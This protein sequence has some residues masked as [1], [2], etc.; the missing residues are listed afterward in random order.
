M[1]SCSQFFQTHSSKSAAPFLQ[2]RRG[3][4]DNRQLLLISLGSCSQ[5]LRVYSPKS[6]APGLRLRTG[7]TKPVRGCSQFFQTQSSKS[8][9]SSL[10]L[11]TGSA[12]SIHGMF[13]V[14]P[15]LQLQ[16]CSFELDPPNQ[17]IGSDT[18]EQLYSSNLPLEMSS[19][20][21]DGD[22]VTQ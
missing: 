4:S 22:E 21:A 7:T 9:A 8:A 2:L 5:L 10:Q 15:N 19:I 20:P 6:A 12:G 13:T 1:D 3:S 16:V 18:A 11:R 14:L 17:L